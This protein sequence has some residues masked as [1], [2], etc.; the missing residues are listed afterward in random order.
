M[1]AV[2]QLSGGGSWPHEDCQEACTA[3]VLYDAGRPDTVPNIEAF[4]FGDGDN[5]SD[6][7]GGQVIVD[8]LAR[9]GI[10]SHLDR[11]PF[12]QV[13]AEARLRGL[14]RVFVAIWSD[15]AGTPSPGS[16]LGH[17]ILWGR[18]RGPDGAWLPERYMQPVGGLLVAYGDDQ[19]AAAS[20]GAPGAGYSVMV[21]VPIGAVQEDDMIWNQDM[22]RLAVIEVRRHYQAWPESLEA[23]DMFANQIA[24]DGSNF[25]AVR[26]AI[27]TKMEADG[28][29][30][31]FDQVAQARAAIQA[32]GQTH[33][34][35]DPAVQAELQK[36]EAQMAAIAK[37]A[38]GG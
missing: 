30:D 5:P 3:S 36:L 10:A 18:E 21:D 33:G 11:R 9:A 23:V 34:A 1:R 17:W 20:Q 12:G 31:L 13:I 8:R 37:A 26:D 6:G 14:N 32:L 38:G 2:D 7:T 24:N 25:L 16:G 29:V 4:D 15:H 35:D 27:K 28:W 22:K 19:V